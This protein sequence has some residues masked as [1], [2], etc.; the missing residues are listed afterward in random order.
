MKIVSIL[1]LSLPFQVVLANP[2]AKIE[3]SKP[4]YDESN[5]AFKGCKFLNLDQD[6]IYS[7]L[8]FKAGDVIQ[9]Q[10]NEMKIEQTKSETQTGELN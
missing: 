10:G 6:S 5:K 4:I 1:L 8:G 7:K 9:P 2:C 3:N